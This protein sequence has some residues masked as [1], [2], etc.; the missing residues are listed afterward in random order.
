M[1]VTT[2]SLAQPTTIVSQP[3]APSTPVRTQ[4]VTTTRTV[5]PNRALLG[6]G[7]MT[8]AAAY[9]PAVVVAGSSNVAADEKLYIPVA[10]PWLDLAQ[11]PA[12][13][14]SGPSCGLDTG[15][16]LLL[17][18]GG[19]AQGIG[20]LT[21][22]ASFFVPERE[23]VVTRTATNATFKPTVHVA[24][25]GMGAGGAGVAAFGTW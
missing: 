3:S 16:K 12:C 18:V 13:A 6:T 17:A 25:A 21:T 10:G 4:E 19:A 5:G 24:P 20:V 2:A 9:I 7:L 14:P 8:F 23:K 22:A 15:N 1:A 11:R